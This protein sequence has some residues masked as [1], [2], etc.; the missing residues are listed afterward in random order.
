MAQEYE[1]FYTFCESSIRCGEVAVDLRGYFKP[2]EIKRWEEIYGRD[3]ER[4]K[5]RKLINGRSVV[6]SIIGYRRVGKSVFAY[7][8]GEVESLNPIPLKVHSGWDAD[9]VFDK[10]NKKIESIYGSKTEGWNVGGGVSLG[11]SGSAS[12]STSTTKAPDIDE[13]CKEKCYIILD[14]VQRL[15]S[16]DLREVV[17]DFYKR[18]ESTATI[19]LTGSSVY[20]IRNLGIARKIDWFTLYPFDEMKAREFIEKGFK[21]NGMLLDADDISTIYHGVGGTPGLIIDVAKLVILRNYD[22]EDAVEHV[23]EDFVSGDGESIIQDLD[24]I[25]N[26]HPTVDKKRFVEFLLDRRTNEFDRNEREL[27]EDLKI[28]GVVKGGI[29]DDPCLRRILSKWGGVE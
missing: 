16:E 2:G 5:F 24:E 8:Y 7:A 27:L 12:K 29:V 4:R 22:I 13:V 14:E 21:Q 17:N 11:I 1:I 25:I 23:Y 18:F 20:K 28:F 19:V 26:Q 6:V 3:P 10:L 9:K 15:K